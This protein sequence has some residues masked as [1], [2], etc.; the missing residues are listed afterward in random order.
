M[1]QAKRSEIDEMNLDTAVYSP[2]LT[3]SDLESSI[4]PNDVSS[5]KN[6]IPI[7]PII[8]KIRY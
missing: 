6:D 5:S 7:Q 1:A 2:S 3:I 8:P 4:R